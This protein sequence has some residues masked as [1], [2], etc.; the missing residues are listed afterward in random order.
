MLVLAQGNVDPGGP[1]VFD[2]VVKRFLDEAQ[3]MNPIFRRNQRINGINL[4]QNAQARTGRQSF[5]HRTERFAQSEPVQFDRT[6]GVANVA[7][8]R[9]RFGGRLG[10]ARNV[11]ASVPRVPAP[12]TA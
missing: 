8:A 1:R 10:D 11:D 6:Q 7:H 9:E 2:D 12:R 5:R 3:D 4:G